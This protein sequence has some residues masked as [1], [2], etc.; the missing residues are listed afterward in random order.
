MAGP[1]ASVFAFEAIG[2]S[3]Q[4]E[5]PVPLGPAEQSAVL[6]RIE[7]FD[8]VYS[9]F[10]GDSL[11]TAI[12]SAEAVG[13]Y[14]F[15]ADSDV[16]FELYDRL[17]AATAGAVDPLV[18]R[19]LELLGYDRDY[20][21]RPAPSPAPNPALRPVAGAS[22]RA[23]W[24][25]DVA[26]RGRTLTTAPAVIDVGAAGKGYLVDLVAGV[27]REHGRTEFVV[28][29]SGDLVHAGPASVR[30]GLEHPLDPTKAIGVATLQN[31]SLCASASN[32]RAWGDGLHH[33]VDGR[34]GSPAREVIATWVVTNGTGAAP[35]ALA[36]GLA[37]ALFFTGAHRLAETFH[38]SYVR[39][40][41]DGRAEISR[42]FPGELFT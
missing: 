13:S 14:E 22:A 21:L 26:R 7:E 1:A 27:L 18:G 36:D 25:A 8:R 17:A 11:V 32:R 28:D 9:R 29:A 40:Y 4:I 34:T 19:D 16:L 6:S 10:R 15:P 20:S 31:A 3:W 41:A 12:A 30:I 23:T 38:F 35:T 42:D 37:T 24:T 39:M 5:T 33:I 2:T